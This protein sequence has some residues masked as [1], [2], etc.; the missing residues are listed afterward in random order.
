M[1]E[2]SN[3]ATCGRGLRTH[4]TKFFVCISWF[5]EYEVT[6]SNCSST[7]LKEFQT[8]TLKHT[9]LRNTYINRSSMLNHRPEATSRI[10]QSYTHNP[11]EKVLKKDSETPKEFEA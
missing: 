8:E 6:E 11:Y 2:A 10:H 3:I 1:G 7:L 9:N 4:H 5:L